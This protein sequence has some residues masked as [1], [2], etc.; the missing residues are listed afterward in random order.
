MYY[1]GNL[2]LI[3]L[4]MVGVDMSRQENKNNLSGSFKEF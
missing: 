4:E 3:N 2:L 1:W